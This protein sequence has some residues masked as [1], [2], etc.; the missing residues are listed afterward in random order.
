MKVLK[1]TDIVSVTA[2]GITFGNHN[3]ILFSECIGEKRGLRCI[4]ERNM[5]AAPAYFDFYTPGT[6]T[7][8]IFDKKGVFSQT[9]NRK[10]F[11]CLQKM[12]LTY[13]Y[14]TYDLS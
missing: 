2:E 6:A 4:A 12:I 11:L 9:K 10:D 13:G 3:P 5:Y 7:R 1:Y 14:T 8:I